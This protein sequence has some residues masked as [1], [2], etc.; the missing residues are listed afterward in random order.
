MDLC[1]EQAESMLI[2]PHVLTSALLEAQRYSNAIYGEECFV[3]AEIM[4]TVDESFELHIT[5]PF[6]DIMINT[7]AVVEFDLS[8]GN[9]VDRRAYHSCKAWV[10]NRGDGA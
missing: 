8:T 9:V 5:N 2:S 6:D 4:P 1:Y 10:T 7:S 3:C